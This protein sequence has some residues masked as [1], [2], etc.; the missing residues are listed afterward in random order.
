MPIEVEQKFRIADPTDVVTRIIAL[1]A[2]AQTTVTQV[3]TY[4]AHPARDFA[5]T[6][7]ALRIRRV[8]EANYVTY[9]GPKL[10]ESTKTRRE[11]EVPLA[12]G[13]PAYLSYDQLLTALSF[14]QVAQVAKTRQR[15]QLRREGQAIE[16]AV[17]A[18]EQVGDFVELEIVVAQES[19]IEA[20]QRA[21]HHL[22]NELQLAGGVRESYLELLLGE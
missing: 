11:I 13:E 7:E 16:L 1:G 3:D 10:D 9:K 14:R 22:A 6:D 4:Y 5:T 15:F 18:V 12:A 21:I 20:A 17:D 2:A 19:G 8:G